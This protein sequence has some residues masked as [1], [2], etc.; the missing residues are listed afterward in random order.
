MNL[1]GRRICGMDLDGRHVVKAHAEE[2][3]ADMEAD[4]EEEWVSVGV[5][6][7]NDRVRI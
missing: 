7:G 1:N 4:M 5:W 3:G 2:R 6:W